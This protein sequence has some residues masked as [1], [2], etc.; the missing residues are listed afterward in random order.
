MLV[1]RTPETIFK[2]RQKSEAKNKKK[3]TSYIN[4]NKSKNNEENENSNK[5]ENIRKSPYLNEEEESGTFLH[6][7]H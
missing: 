4:E 6:Y 3:K 2:P 1:S 5:E 7:K